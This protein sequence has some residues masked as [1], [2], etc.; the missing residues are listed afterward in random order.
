MLF[1]LSLENIGKASILS[2]HYPLLV[3]ALSCTCHVSH[4]KN[5]HVCNESLSQ[6][7]DCIA[8][9]TSAYD[10]YLRGCFKASANAI[11]VQDACAEAR[12]AVM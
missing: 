7:K 10:H 9:S 11:L 4:F 12:R 8:Q 5:K 2:A 1:A 3:K 6:H